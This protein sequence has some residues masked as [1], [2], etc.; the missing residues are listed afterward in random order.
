MTYVHK[1]HASVS[2]SIPH[3][4]VSN[5]FVEAQWVKIHRPKCKNVVI[6]NIY[7]PP[8]GDIGEFTDYL[9]NCLGTL[10][11][12]KTEIFILGDFNVNYKNK[13]S[14]VFKKLNFCIKATG[15]SQ[16]ITNTTRNT[17]KSKTLLDLILTN[18]KYVRASGTLDH[19]I[20]YHQPIFVVK[21]KEGI[22]GPKWNLRVGPTDVLTKI[23]S[24]TP[25][26]NVGR[27]L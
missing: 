10:N 1:T 21:K 4:N 17:D 20:T 12:D 27:F 25:A 11:L 2:E 9:E 19:F 6:C 22:V 3:L 15:F 23:F 7:R 18:S 5:G 26:G 16:L 24:G 8:T 13:A 14:A